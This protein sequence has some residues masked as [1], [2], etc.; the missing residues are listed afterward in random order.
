MFTV[1]TTGAGSFRYTDLNITA[2]DD[3]IQADQDHYISSLFQVQMS[4][5][6]KS[7]KSNV[8][9]AVENKGSDLQLG[10]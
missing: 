2:Q 3:G 5:S 6:R 1:G 10:Q 8:L 4:P 7:E 9:T